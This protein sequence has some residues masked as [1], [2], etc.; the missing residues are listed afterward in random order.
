ME[1]QAWS[2][3]GEAYYRMK[4]PQRARGCFRESDA[5]ASSEGEGQADLLFLNTYHEWKMAL[6]DDNPT[7]ARIAFGRLK[8]LRSSLE[9]RRPEVEAFDE[10]VERGRAHA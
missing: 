3:L 2:A 5:L 6:E 1:C 8:T 9:R 4:D 10:Y 7:R